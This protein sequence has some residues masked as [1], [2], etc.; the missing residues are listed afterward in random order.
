V[1]SARLESVRNEAR[2]SCDGLF[3]GQRFDRIAGRTKAFCN[4]ARKAGPPNASI[5]KSNVIEWNTILTECDTCDYMES[6]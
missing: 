6:L 5:N 2:T 1:E 3:D 4:G